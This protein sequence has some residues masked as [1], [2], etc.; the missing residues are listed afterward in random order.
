M[1]KNNNQINDKI[2][3]PQVVLIDSAGI[4]LGIMDTKTALNKAQNESLDLVMVSPE[5][6]D[7]VVCKLLDFGKYIFDKKKIM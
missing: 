5:N 4:N 2:K 7:P 3:A 6:A 1:K